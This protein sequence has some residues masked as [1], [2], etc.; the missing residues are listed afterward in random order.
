MSL[1]SEN[2]R[3]LEIIISILSL[4]IK[5]SVYDVLNKSLR[6]LTVGR[7]L[8]FAFNDTNKANG[9]IHKQIVKYPST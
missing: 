7:T 6:S 5:N 9:T 1:S 4:D 3:K 8:S 2:K